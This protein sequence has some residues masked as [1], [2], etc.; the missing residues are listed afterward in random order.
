MNH[1]RV[2]L[3][4][5]VVA[6]AVLGTAGYDVVQSERSV[7]VATAPDDSAYLALQRPSEPPVAVTNGTSGEI[8]HVENRFETPVDVTLE[9]YEGDTDVVARRGLNATEDIEPGETAA[10][11]A[12]VYCPVPDTTH[13]VQVDLHAE[14]ADGSVSVTVTGESVTVL[15]AE[16]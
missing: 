2:V 3:G 12:Y 5:F 14:S 11:S 13:E 10:L 15:C 4:L 6:A 9:A 8:L 1:S 7:D 16:R